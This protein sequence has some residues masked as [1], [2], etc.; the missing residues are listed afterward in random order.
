MIATSGRHCGQGFSRPRVWTPR[1]AGGETSGESCQGPAWPRDRERR[2]RS[3]RDPA[4]SSSSDGGQARRLSLCLPRVAPPRA[5]SMP[6]RRV[7]GDEGDRR[8]ALPILCR[9]LSALSL[10][11]WRAAPASQS[12]AEK[13]GSRLSWFSRRHRN[14]GVTSSPLKVIFQSP[15]LPAACQYRPG[16]LYF[17]DLQAHH[18]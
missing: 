5:Q 7:D 11:S 15:P 14:T 16:F 12:R 3:T 18:S 4:S 8:R 9:T 13:S 6:P 17:P 1:L 10:T 2:P